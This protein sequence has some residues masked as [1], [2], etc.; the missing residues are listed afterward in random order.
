M[1]V[2]ELSALSCTGLLANL[3][4]WVFYWQPKE[5]RDTI[6]LATIADEKADGDTYHVGK[7]KKA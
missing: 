3:T 6:S 5:A 2:L 7:I 4:Q 1:D